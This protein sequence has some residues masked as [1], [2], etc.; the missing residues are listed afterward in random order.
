M[1]VDPRTA[2]LSKHAQVRYIERHV[3]RAGVSALRRRGLSDGAIL[4][5]IEER[6]HDELMSLREAAANA[7]ARC[8]DA[9]D[10]ALRG[11][12]VCLVF[13][14]TRVVVKDGV[15]VTTLPERGPVPHRG[16]RHTS[17]H[18]RYRLRQLTDR[19]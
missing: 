11:L 13:N 16:R 12:A 2:R 10:G 7:S 8:D 18:Q 4:H 15:F 6:R 17:R 9:L 1:H 3:D 5:A 19:A 14:G